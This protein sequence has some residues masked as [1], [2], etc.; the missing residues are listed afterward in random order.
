M[1]AIRRMRFEMLEHAQRTSNDTYAITLSSEDGIDSPCWAARGFE[2]V[3]M[4][5]KSRYRTVSGKRG[6]DV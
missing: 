6:I 1:Y 3:A 4:S 2:R 5:F